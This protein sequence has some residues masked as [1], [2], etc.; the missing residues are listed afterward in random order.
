MD[1]DGDLDGVVSSRFDGRIVWY[2]N[3]GNSDFVDYHILM[4]T[5]D[6]NRHIV[7]ADF[8]NNGLADIVIGK[9]PLGDPATRL[10][11]NTGSGFI[12]SEIQMPLEFSW[13]ER[14]ESNDLDM[15]G[16]PDL[17]LF[18]RPTQK[19]CWFRSLGNG[20][21]A[22]PIVI[23]TPQG[24]T[25]NSFHDINGDG[26]MDVFIHNS[27]QRRFFCMINDGT[28]QFIL[29]DS[30]P[31]DLVNKI[32]GVADVDG[33]GDLDIVSDLFVMAVHSA[34]VW[35][36]N[37]GTGQYVAYHQLTP[38]GPEIGWSPVRILDIDG[39]PGVEIV[40]SMPVR[41]YTVGSDHMFTVQS[42]S[43]FADQLGVFEDF[44]GDGLPDLCTGLHVLVNNG[45]GGNWTDV[46]AMDNPSHVKD[47]ELVDVNKD[48]LADIVASSSF[49]QLEV[50]PYLGDG[51]Y[52]RRSTVISQ[53]A[54]VYHVMPVD[55]NNDGL[56]DIAF[57]GWMS[58]DFN[59]ATNPFDSGFWPREVLA[60]EQQSGQIISSAIGDFDG[61]GDLDL[62]TV[63]I[64]VAGNEIVLHRNQGNGTYAEEAIAP[65]QEGYLSGNM[66]VFDLDGDGD[67]DVALAENGEESFTGGITV[68]IND[69]SGHFNV[70]DL[71]DHT[72]AHSTQL[73]AADFDDDGDMDILF[74]NSLP[75]IIAIYEHEDGNFIRHV[76]D[77]P[78]HYAPY[79]S[80]AMDVD[81]DG[82]V[83]V[84]GFS[85]H[86][87][88]ILNGQHSGIYWYRNLGEWQFSPPYFV[89]VPA[90]FAQ[91]Y[92]IETIDRDFDGDLDLFMSD[93]DG[94]IYYF[95]NHFWGTYR[96]QGNVFFDADE[97]GMLS[98]GDV[99]FPQLSIQVTPAQSAFF[100]NAQ[101]EYNALCGQGTYTVT[102][103]FDPVLWTLST[104][105]E[106]YT[107]NVSDSEPVHTG[108]D[109]GIVP[110][111]F[112]PNAELVV[113]DPMS[114]C[115][116]HGSMWVS[117]RN[118]GNT[119]LEGV[120]TV[121]LDGLLTYQ[122]AYPEPFAISGNTLQ[123]TV[124]SL[125]YY[126]LTQWAIVVEM[127][128]ETQIGEIMHNT[129]GFTDI[130]GFIA[131]N[132]TDAPTLCAYD[133]NDKTEHTG[134]GPTGLISDG[135]WLVYTVRFQNTGNSVATD[136]V[137]RDWLSKHLD[138]ASLTPLSW[139]FTPE[140]SVAPDGETVFSFKNIMLPDSGSDFAAS[141]GF[142][143][144]KVRAR[145]HLLP[146]TQIENTANI[147]FD[148]NP[149]I[150]TNTVLN[151]LE[152]Y[153]PS[154]LII[155]YT[156]P[157]LRSPFQHPESQQW[158]LNGEPIS[159]ALGA[160]YTPLTS[161]V[162][163]VH[164]VYPEECKL[165][166]S[167][168][169]HSMIGLVDHEELSAKVRPNPFRGSAIIEL[170]HA[171]V[172]DFHLCVTDLMG[173]TVIRKRYQSTGLI[174]IREGE[175]DKGF[176]LLYVETGKSR[177]FIGKVI[178]Q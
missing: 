25:V 110:N 158:Y 30:I 148:L 82:L 20:L 164:A 15:D 172:G 4:E 38:E 119:V 53:P 129:A 167:L 130:S 26:S 161:G 48:G 101:G 135:Q 37:D 22:E 13:I 147:F 7:V 98:D 168:Y 87:G 39:E 14:L 141:Q 162:Y 154:G 50:L 12:L 59:L 126:E 41:T 16:I 175:L 144:Y 139:S 117:L 160:T 94:S 18:D 103:S 42:L 9:N 77:E 140:I 84:I 134:L 52:A 133:P 32:H 27:L 58:G 174:E 91:P 45:S 128:D 155:T 49:S 36:E 67:L 85:Q 43:G 63:P 156:E 142:I 138:L 3:N 105:N 33:D 104:P 81:K 71:S 121:E 96:V 123:F 34:L 66:I 92:D 11:R 143:R 10:M 72:T 151:T 145:D 125:S 102:P 114:P 54:S 31:F 95:E 60:T 47:F 69:G 80:H 127:P 2:E 150:I 165:E 76:I 51:S 131:D 28:G 176:F 8:G 157:K 17:I 112:Q 146:G 86:G 55:Y 170:S 106:S 62:I 137:I 116:V 153:E 78:T 75:G 65:T 89:H 169:D 124:D 166:S 73:S 88:A 79:A 19:A 68:F 163:Q 109:F 93:M 74:N 108:L 97:N 29:T 107:V 21:F 61:D 35:L 178:S 5:E 177:N 149:P 152:C 100:T 44:N 159:G 132:Q 115:N 23:E 6:A 70:I 1:G 46:R 111:G 64:S 171:P 173:R 99:P 40:A 56:V 136:V 122:S 120:V 90:R 118:T 113:I 24:T 83:D 57:T